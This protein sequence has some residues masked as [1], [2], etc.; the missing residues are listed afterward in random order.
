MDIT[1]QKKSFLQGLASTQS[2]VERKST[3]PILANCCLEAK[4][5]LL[6]ISATDLEVAISTDIPVETKTA[7]KVTVSARSLFDIVKAMSE[8]RIQLEVLEGNRV[9]IRAGKSDFKIVGLPADEFPTLPRAAKVPTH[10]IDVAAFQEMIAKTA[11]AMSTDETRYNLNGM[12]FEQVEDEAKGSCLRLVA[13]DGHRLSYA[14]RPTSGKMKLEKGGIIPR[15]GI[16][17]WKKLLD[18]AEENFTLQIDEKYIT[19]QRENT[20]LIVRLIDG[21]FPPYRQV[22][23][24]DSEWKIAVNREALQS[25][26]RRVQLVTTDRARGVKFKLSP[27]HLEVL[28]QNPDVGEAHEELQAS[29]KGKTFEIGFNAR[30]FSD[31]LSVIGDEEVILELKGEMGPCIIRSEYDKQFLAVIMPMRLS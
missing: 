26:L 17:E 23:P 27:G 30:Y 13:T 6:T 25:S 16:L 28:A 10:A 15:K 18:G 20:T 2:V 11:Y 4:D 14:D 31:V 12:Y 29:Y 22:I 24:K 8:D 19:V 5:K 21:Q 3:M 9:H 7:G 1:V